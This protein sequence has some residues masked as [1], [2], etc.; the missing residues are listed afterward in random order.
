[1]VAVD[2]DKPQSAAEKFRRATLVHN[3][4]G[5]RV[6]QHGPPGR[7]QVGKCQRVGGS[8]GTYQKYRYVAL[9]QIRKP[10]FE[11]LGQGIVP[12][13]NG[14]SGV[15][16]NQSIQDGGGNSGGVIAGKV[17]C[18]S[19]SWSASFAHSHYHA[20][21]RAE[22]SARWIVLA[23]A[24]KKISR[25]AGNLLGTTLNPCQNFGICCIRTAML[26]HLAG[27]IRREGSARGLV[28]VTKGAARDSR[29]A[30]LR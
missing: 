22:T 12:I 20:T 29:Q 10:A 16:A 2:A 18:R 17:H 13:G 24:K 9:K 7:R 19:P 1:A 28:V 3:G 14:K 21:L 26:S 27:M 15:G 25:E 11:P 5:L 6:A 23:P 30:S 4:V 8:A